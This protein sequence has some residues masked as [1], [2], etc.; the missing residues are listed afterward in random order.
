ME[1]LF[2]SPLVR[3]V[4]TILSRFLQQQQQN[5]NKNKTK[6]KNKKKKN[7][8]K[9]N[10]NNNNNNNIKSQNIFH[11][12]K[13][14]TCSSNCKYRTAATPCLRNIVCFR[15]ITVNNLH[16]GGTKDDDDD[17]DDDNNN[18]NNNN[19]CMEREMSQSFG[20]KQYIQTEKL[21]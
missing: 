4:L 15:Y 16:K 9:N 14:V 19:N 5:K 1:K 13:K 21:Q 17:D 3:S 11:G 18:N 2:L 8:K 12:R 6:N 7:N 20:I 10:S